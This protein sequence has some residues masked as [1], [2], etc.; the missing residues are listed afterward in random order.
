MLPN[1]MI[2]L[3]VSDCAVLAESLRKI[4]TRPRFFEYWTDLA[5]VFRTP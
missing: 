3:D 2:V 1:F 5:P 4:C